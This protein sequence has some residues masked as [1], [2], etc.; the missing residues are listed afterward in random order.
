MSFPNVTRVN[1]TTAG[2]TQADPQQAAAPAPGFFQ[3]AANEVV[4]RVANVVLN[5]PTARQTTRDIGV[6]TPKRFEDITKVASEK[7]R[8]ASGDN[9]L[10]KLIEAF[11]PMV[12]QKICTVIR[13]KKEILIPFVEN[14]EKYL[15]SIA[16]SIIFKAVANLA[17]ETRKQ[18]APLKDGEVAPDFNKELAAYLINFLKSESDQVKADLD[19]GDEAQNKRVYDKA[20]GRLMRQVLPNG[21][22]DFEFARPITIL[23]ITTPD[24]S[25]EIWDAVEVEVIPGLLKKLYPLLST[26]AANPEVLKGKGGSALK[27]LSAF[28]GNKAKKIGPKLLK[29]HSGKI[30]EDLLKPLEGV[31]SPE[32]VNRKLKEVIESIASS[33]DERLKSVWRCL[34]DNATAIATE[35]F[36]GLAS[37]TQGNLVPEVF[38]KVLKR[39]DAFFIA[40]KEAIDAGI[41][42]TP[43]ADEEVK[44]DEQLIA[45]FKPL[46]DDLIKDAKL[47][48]HEVISLL[49]NTLLPKLALDYYRQMYRY[50]SK[51]AGTHEDLTALC[52]VLAEDVTKIA[53][54]MAKKDSKKIASVINTHLFKENKLDEEGLGDFAEGLKEFFNQSSDPLTHSWSYAQKLIQMAISKT[55]NKVEETSKKANKSAGSFVV[56]KILEILNKKMP[57]IHKQL[58]EIEKSKKTPQEKTKEIRKAFQPAVN[59]FIAIAGG[60]VKDLFTVPDSLK[61]LLDKKLR[62]VY[63]PTIFHSVYSDLTKWQRNIPSYEGELRDLFGTDKAKKIVDTLSGKVQEMVPDYLEKNADQVIKMVESSAGKYFKALSAK[64]QGEFRSMISKGLKQIGTDPSTNPLWSGVA[65][66]VKAVALKAF[67]GYGRLM[68]KCDTTNAKGDREFVLKTSVDLL[69][70]AENHFKTINVIPKPGRSYPAHLVDHKVL[71]EGFIKHKQLHAAMALDLDPNATEAQKKKQRMDKFYIPLAADLISLADVDDPTDFPLPMGMSKQQVLDMVKTKILPMVLEKAFETSMKREVVNKFML[72]A[73]DVLNKVSESLKPEEDDKVVIDDPEQK[74]L[75][76]KC[77][78][79]V[80]TL[81]QLVPEQFTQTIFE[82][83]SI[84]K[85]TA[86]KIGQAVRKK[87]RNTSIMETMA[88]VIN[89]FTMPD[90]SAK[91]TRSAQ[92]I[93]EDNKKTEEALHDTMKKTIS[94]HARKKLDSYIDDKF[95]RF[96]KFMEN[97]FSKCFGSFGVKIKNC[98]RGFFRAVFRI[99]RPIKNF[100]IDKIVWY[101]VNK[102]IESKSKEII[103]DAHM[104]IHESLRFKMAETVVKSL[105]EQKKKA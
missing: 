42:E 79:M 32:F 82:I 4:N 72:D 91:E 6:G 70:V 92:K 63:L 97:L 58:V 102:K 30:A 34:Q 99:F 24:I 21:H 88:K 38:G 78:K 93:A 19:D 80:Q 81:M 103:E 87:T 15:Q 73:V 13:E 1:H 3:W 69:E 66:Y 40:N 100:F 89:G 98:F 84:K 57:E 55:F 44:R 105:K 25:K 17:E 12:T 52:G 49:K 53:K 77:G 95:D 2:T 50:E 76:I 86:E 26:K 14:E 46:V 8:V 7:L 22:Q 41:Q 33:D 101:F 54:D 67:V 90:L 85:M 59:E 11:V 61:D 68:K 18:M 39:M 37:E 29:K 94:S 35:A 45:L 36:A 75:N 83:D 20:A 47:E 60:D 62:T 64:Q 23:G 10:S 71:L 74:E 16:R 43:G 27:A 56:G 5:N 96:D 51:P 104:R 9:E 65:Q 28:I 48:N 31:N